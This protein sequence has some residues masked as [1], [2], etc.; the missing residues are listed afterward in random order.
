M[1]IATEPVIGDSIAYAQKEILAAIR[2]GE[3]PSVLC[4]YAITTT[5]EE[6]NL[7]Y[8]LSGTEY[9]HPIY[10]RKKKKPLK[11]LGLAGSR[12]EAYELVRSMIQHYVEQDALMEM[13]A[14]LEAL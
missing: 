3:H 1:L 7:F 5:Y 12:Q 13:K 4:W 14:A 10:H 2:K 6:C 8:I 9:R 11:L